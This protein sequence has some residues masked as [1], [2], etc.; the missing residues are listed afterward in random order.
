MTEPAGFT[1]V[2]EN[3]HATRI[4]RRADPRVGTDELGREAIAFVDAAGASRWLPVSE[5]EQE[6]ANYVEGKIKHVRLALRTAL[7][8]DEAEAATALAYLE[9]IVRGQ[10]DS[11]A[12]FVDL[13]VDEV[14]L[15]LSEQIDAMRWLVRTVTT[16]TASP[17]AV[18][19]P[20][21]PVLAAGIEEALRQPDAAP[22]MV[23]SASV[24]R[25]EA[26][27]LAVEAG[28]PVIVTATGESGM[29]SEAADRIA[30]ATHIVELALGRGIPLG[31]IHVDPLVFPVAVQGDSVGHCL[32]AY[33]ELRERFGPEIHLT[34]GM[35]NVSFG[36]PQRRLL[37]EAFVLLA[38]DA[39]AD[40]GIL[41]PVAS[42]L[43]RVLALDRGTR[44]FQLAVDALTGA[45]RGCR[46]YLGAYRA[47]E[48]QPAETSG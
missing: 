29:P 7:A 47:G 30:N 24:E 15:E 1:V 26:L 36:L 37:N 34:G 25:L 22:P 28:G 20:S 39:G 41:D 45:D 23:N 18:D 32:T 10:L 44:P 43:D 11:G 12:D 31:S 35:S 27:D 46:A 21:P 19:S 9:T 38:V 48:L 42:P 13:N 17:V 14:S 2:G 33:R 40:S 6:S 8:G 16:W 4:V 3:V 5:S